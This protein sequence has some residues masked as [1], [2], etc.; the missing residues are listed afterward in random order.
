M[1]TLKVNGVSY[2]VDVPDEMPILWVLRDVLGL[3]GTKFGCAAAQCGACM[4]HLDGDGIRS[5]VTPVARA[6]DREIVTIEGLNDAIG[7]SVQAAWEEVDVPQCGYCQSGQ[8]MAATILLREN[9]APTDD[10]I[11]HAMSGNICRC[12]TYKRIRAA[13]HLAAKT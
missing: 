12:G 5:C 1:I 10:D 4:V 8:I 11:N 2:G 9:P 13:I 7:R 3:T 6:A